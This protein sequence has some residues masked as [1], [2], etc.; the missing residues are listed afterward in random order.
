MKT[1]T[2]VNTQKLTQLALLTAI[3][4]LMAFTPIGYIKTF[5]L[6]ITLIVIPV[7]VGAIVAGPAA[8]AFLGGVFGITSFIQCF[9]MSPFGAALLG[10]NPVAT[11]V[12]CLIPRILMGWLSG[13]IFIGLRKSGLKEIAYPAA[14]LSGALLNTLFFMTALLAF[15]YRSDYIQGIS[16]SL[17]GGNIF[18]FVIAFV[19]INGL[20]EAVT[21]F[22]IGTAIARALDAFVKRNARESRA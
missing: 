2:G 20:V 7:T 16:E 8:G 17:G 13:L 19:G 4:I 12:V 11:F 1:K 9:G 18:Q 5:G 14:S 10:I 15:F 6:E 21:C 22:V 3:I